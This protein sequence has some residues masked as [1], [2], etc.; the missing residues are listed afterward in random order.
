ML[1]LTRN[2]VKFCIAC[3]E[4]DD[5]FFFILFVRLMMTISAVTTNAV[6]VT[7]AMTIATTV[8]A[9]KLNGEIEEGSSEPKG[10]MRSEKDE[11]QNQM[12]Q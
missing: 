2:G 7:K 10:Y 12:K 9:S 11:L 8:T 3:T 1:P 6:S 4:A 5:F